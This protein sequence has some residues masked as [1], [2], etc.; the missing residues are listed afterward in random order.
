MQHAMVI[1][2]IHKPLCKV[3]AA[4]C[5][6]DGGIYRY[7]MFTDGSMK[8]EDHIPLD[9]PM[10]F[11]KKNDVF[12][13]LLRSPDGLNDESGYIACQFG[14]PVPPPMTT[15]GKVA[16]HLCE[17]NNRI[18]AVNYVSG[19]VSEI[20]VKTVVHSP[21]MIGTDLWPEQK[22]KFPNAWQKRRI[23]NQSGRQ[24]SP[25]THQVIPAPDGIFLI[26]ADL[27]LDTVFV[28]NTELKMIS[29]QKMPK[30]SGVRHMI[31]GKKKK[32]GSYPLFCVCELD[33]TVCTLSYND[34]QLC[35]VGAESS[36]IIRSDNTA[37]A[38]RISND[39][40]FLY[41]SQRGDDCIS[42]FEADE[43][44]ILTWLFNSPCGGSNPRDFCLTPE[45][46]YL[47]C[48][49]E[50]SGS[51]TVLKREKNILKLCFELPLSSALC[52]YAE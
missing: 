1:Q 37:A 3:Y 23:E 6:Q 33:S 38:I 40:R 21:D 51:L 2:M 20:G 47:I 17:V 31:F 10:Y 19:S 13:T 43:N 16:C 4:A 9:S 18:Y 42:V 45:N 25:H 5:T 29:F 28:Y 36:H 14:K 22:I 32:D 41:A 24:N 12:H 46:N 48:A 26:V 7:Q 15:N 35:F 34:G 11:I 44:G 27:G 49:N 50:K 8:E 30:M 39:S 52:V